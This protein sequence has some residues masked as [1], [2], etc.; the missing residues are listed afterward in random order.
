MK[1]G[2]ICFTAAGRAVCGRLLS[3]FK[4]NGD[5]CLAWAP[6]RLLEECPGEE[7]IAPLEGG[8]SEWSRQR[9]EEGRAMIFI[10]AAG[11]AVRAVAPWVKDKLSDPPVV[12]VDEKARFVI[13]ILSGH[14][15]GGNRLALR[16]G[17]W[18][19][20]TPVITTATDVNGL[21]AVDVYAAEQGLVITD[22]REAKSISAAVLEGERIGFF[23]DLKETFGRVPE[24]CAEEA[25][26]HNIWITVKDETAPV[27]WER[28]GGSCLRLVPRAVVLGVGC[29]RGIR[30]EVLEKQVLKALRDHQ[31]SLESVKALATID[32]KKDEKAILRLA[33]AY[34]WELRFYEAERLLAVEGDFKESAFVARTV[35]VGN[36][37]ERAAAAEGG[38]LLIHKQAG[39][40]TA[41]AA[42]LE[43]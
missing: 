11:I 39:M 38:Q 35:G 43:V 33:E 10:G 36:V 22:R 29:R 4:E 27:S 8:L 14:V 19:G 24:G 21:F 7:D 34:G 41:V 1:I 16:I 18:L 3:H 23:S 42:A 17:E 25:G 13:P 20:S 28:K 5:D 31:I 32:I 15:G 30:K 12:V 9:F 2:I 6:Q 40:G 37:C 26:S